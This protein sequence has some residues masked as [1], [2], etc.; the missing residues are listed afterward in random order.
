MNNSFFNTNKKTIARIIVWGALAFA[1]VVILDTQGFFNFYKDRGGVIRLNP[2]EYAESNSLVQEVIYEVRRQRE[3]AT[4]GAFEENRKNREDDTIYINGIPSSEVTSYRLVDREY[5]SLGN[6]FKYGIVCKPDTDA[7]GG[8]L[9]EVSTGR[10]IPVTLESLVF[11]EEKYLFGLGG[12]ALGADTGLYL[13]SLEEFDKELAYVDLL[14]AHNNYSNAFKIADIDNDDDSYLS[15]INL[16]ADKV[17]F[18]RTYKE[19]NGERTLLFEYFVEI[20]N[21]RSKVEVV[22]TVDFLE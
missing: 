16:S 22:E 2:E 15:E 3:T 12:G 9:T 6:N 1:A 7:C 20:K 4:Q 18:K 13:V 21:P 11:F 14:R 19:K 17:T 8:R 5:F 10:T